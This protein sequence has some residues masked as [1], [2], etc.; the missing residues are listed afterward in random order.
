MKLFF[1]IST[2][3]L[4]SLFTPF[5]FARTLT[6]SQVIDLTFKQSPQALSIDLVPKRTHYEIMTARSQYDTTVQTTFSHNIDKN[7]QTSPV[8]GTSNQT[9]NFDLTV[10][11]TT[12]LGTIFETGFLNLRTKSNSIFFT[13]PELYDSRLSFTATQPLLRNSFGHITRQKVNLAKKQYRTSLFD[14][15]GRKLD[16]VHQNLLLYWD[17]FLQHELLYLQ[18]EAVFLARRILTVNLKKLN[19][20]LIERVDLYGFQAN[21]NVVENDLLITEENIARLADKL[22]ATLNLPLETTI[23][24]AYQSLPGKVKRLNTVLANV[25]AGNP[26]LKSLQEDLKTHDI[27]ISIQRNARLPQLDL[28]GSLQLNGIDPNYGQAVEDIGGYHPNWTVGLNFQ[29]PLQNREARAEYQKLLLIKKQKLLNYQDVENQIMALAKESYKRFQTT[30]KRL[31]VAKDTIY[32][33]QRKWEAELVRYNQG[34]SAPDM[35]IR[36]QNDY[37]N[38][39]ALYLQAQVAHQVAKTDLLYVQGKLK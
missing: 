5:G 13:N 9:T 12:P 34:R 31:K 24:P 10:S 22:K 37:V 29:F 32:N 4:L 30:A 20:G 3:L 25:L 36:F 7:E 14:A 18:K 38:A 33:Q 21:L 27:V 19:L 11:Q 26:A 17:W 2:G 35:V 8:F 1:L 15:E 6:A 16:L 23:T 28:I 39:K